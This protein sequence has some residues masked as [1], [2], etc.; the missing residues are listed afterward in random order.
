MAVPTLRGTPGNKTKLNIK[1]A[2]PAART[3]KTGRALAGNGG[4]TSVGS[5]FRKDSTFGGAYGLSSWSFTV[6]QT[7]KFLD[8]ALYEASEFVKIFFVHLPMAA[9][10][11]R[12]LQS[13]PLMNPVFAR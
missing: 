2:M 6:G 1:Q 12:I 3:R 9:P 11:G 7:T 4:L 8:T 10:R 13:N 5:S